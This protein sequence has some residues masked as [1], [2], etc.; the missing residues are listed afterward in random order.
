MKA[1][2]AVIV[3]VLIVLIVL[4]LFFISSLALMWLVNIVLTHYGALNLDYQSALAITAILWLFGG[5][6]RGTSNSN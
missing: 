2:A 3:I 1:L 4:A 5:A 6:I